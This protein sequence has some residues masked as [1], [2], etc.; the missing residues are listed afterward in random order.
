MLINNALKW[1][2][3]KFLGKGSWGSVYLAKPA[4]LFS[5]SFPP[6]MALKSAVANLS[7]TLQLE[8][9]ILHDLKDCPEIVKCFGSDFS[10]ENGKLVYNLLLEYANG[11]TL[12]ELIERSGDR[13]QEWEASKYTCMLL[14]GLC[15]VH[16]K[17]YVHCDLK[18]DNV[19]VFLSKQKNG[20]LEYF[21]K[22]ADFGLAKRTRCDNADDRRHNLETLLGVANY[23]VAI[24]IRSLGCI[25]AEMLVGKSLWCD[26]L[27]LD[28][29][30]M[31]MSKD[32]D[33]K[34]LEILPEF[35]SKDAKDFVRT[36]MTKNKNERWSGDRLL[37]HPFITQFVD[38]NLD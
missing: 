37:K 36:C 3:I 6:F 33:E 30:L 8:K 38:V 1:E 34:W 16:H 35:M 24:D 14:K 17:G 13:M 25:V 29:M 9:T 4:P 20:E 22:I 12:E 19:L 21:L 31:I 28:F 26:N 10:V 5:S 11:G 15:H 23:D 27:Q 32:D 2:K 7:S 18:A